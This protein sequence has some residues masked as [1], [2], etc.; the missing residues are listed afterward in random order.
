MIYCNKRLPRQ[1]RARSD[2]RPGLTSPRILPVLM[3]SSVLVYLL[4]VTQKVQ[5]RSL[6]RRNEQ[7]RIVS[8]SPGL[9]L[10]TAHTY[11]CRPRVICK[12]TVNI[13]YSVVSYSVIPFS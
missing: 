2:A 11:Y 1:K 7:L 6:R 5:R 3:S 8:D 13:D 9:S 12:C 10:L 4:G